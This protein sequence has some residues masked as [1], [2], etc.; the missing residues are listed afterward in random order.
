V[1][2]RL[3]LAALARVRGEQVFGRMPIIT[4]EPAAAERAST[5]T[6]TCCPRTSTTAWSG[7]ALTSFPGMTF[8]FG[9]R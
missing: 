1:Q 8:I 2:L 6:V 4:A 5:A 9:S 7:S 3:Q